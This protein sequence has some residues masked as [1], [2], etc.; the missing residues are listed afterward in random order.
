MATVPEM[1]SAP[2]VQHDQMAHVGAG[3]WENRLSP[4]PGPGED[5]TV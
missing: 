3:V 4:D 1:R 5:L 2:Y